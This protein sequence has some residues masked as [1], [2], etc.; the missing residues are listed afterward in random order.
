MENPNLRTIQ[1]TREDMERL[2]E[3]QKASGE[4]YQKYHEDLQQLREEHL[5][6]IYRYARGNNPSEKNLT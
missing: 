2:E 5:R 6:I 3:I 1:F 4:L